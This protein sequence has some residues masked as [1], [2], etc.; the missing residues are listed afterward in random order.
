MNRIL[1]QI[2]TDFTNIVSNGIKTAQ[3]EWVQNHS[4]SDKAQKPP[5]LNIITFRDTFPC[6][7]TIKQQKL[8]QKS[9]GLISSIS[10]E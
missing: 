2:E 9:K 1:Y 7:K 3:R 4:I 5:K 10:R 6:N 8:P